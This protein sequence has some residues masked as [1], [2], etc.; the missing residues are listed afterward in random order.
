[1]RLMQHE[2][3]YHF[4]GKDRGIKIIIFVD[5]RLLTPLQS[6]QKKCYN[7]HRLKGSL[8][9]NKCLLGFEDVLTARCG[10]ERGTQKLG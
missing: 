7:F 2:I 10:A 1:M 6:G 8:G 4:A 5:Y 9:Q 3:D